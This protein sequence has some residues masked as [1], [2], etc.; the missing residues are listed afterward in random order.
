[1]TNQDTAYLLI[2]G[3]MHLKTINL[4][5]IGPY[6]KIPQAVGEID[7]CAPGS[8]KVWHEEDLVLP[9]EGYWACE[10]FIPALGNKTVTCY[11]AEGYDKKQACLDVDSYYN[12][13]A[14][15]STDRRELN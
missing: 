10:L 8:E 7:F 11:I 15:S 2:G 12:H 4:P 9:F 1:M 5:V 14:L 13:L 3:S 6:I